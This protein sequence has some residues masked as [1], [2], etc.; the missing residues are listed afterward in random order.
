MTSSN[1]ATS[2]LAGSQLRYNLVEGAPVAVERLVQSK[3]FASG[4]E[5]PVW[6][7]AKV[8]SVDYAVCKVKFLDAGENDGGFSVPKDDVQLLRFGT[9][10]DDKHNC[11]CCYWEAE[12]GCGES[13]FSV[14]APEVL[15]LGDAVLVLFQNGTHPS[16]AKDAKYRGRVIAVGTN[17]GTP[18][19]TV[20]YDNGDVEEGIPYREPGVLALL[21]RNESLPNWFEEVPLVMAP[22]SDRQVDENVSYVRTASLKEN[23]AVVVFQEMG[24]DEAPGRKFSETHP[25]DE[26]FARVVEQ[27]MNRHEHYYKLPKYVFP[28]RD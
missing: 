13:S 18:V 16:T 3:F 25:Y 24:S 11:Y 19:A 17:N 5:V 15:N 7:P 6:F 20:A 8:L 21:E 2:S 23:K 27:G 14:G 9:T 22:N 4:V 10:K 26:V 12:D 1:S 28:P